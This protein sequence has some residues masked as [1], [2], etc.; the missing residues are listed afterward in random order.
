[1]RRWEEFTAAA[2]LPRWELFER[3]MEGLVKGFVEGA[4]WPLRC[5]CRVGCPA[6]AESNSNSNSMTT[7]R[8]DSHTESRSNF[9]STGLLLMVSTTHL[10]DKKT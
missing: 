9:C 3:F 1:M 8:T 10:T 7:A 6:L 2:R 4:C 5:V